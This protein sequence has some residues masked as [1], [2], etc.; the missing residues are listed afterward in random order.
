M[1][2]CCDS[3]HPVSDRDIRDNGQTLND[4]DDPDDWSKIKSW[5]DWD[6][7]PSCDASEPMII[8]R[9]MVFKG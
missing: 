1:Y 6:G 9:K 5:R 8:G 3:L 4:N 7:C 2:L